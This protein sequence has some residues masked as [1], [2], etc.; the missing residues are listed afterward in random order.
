MAPQ[1]IWPLFSD[2]GI[3]LIKTFDPR[4]GPNHPRTV[5]ALEINAQPAS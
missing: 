1:G 5:V 4:K 2:S 3:F